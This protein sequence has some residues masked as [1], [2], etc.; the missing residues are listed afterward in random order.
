[1][2]YPSELS[3]LT[4]TVEVRSPPI[5]TLPGFGE[6]VIEQDGVP[7]PPPPPEGEGLGAAAQ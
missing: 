3:L 4:V 1:M 5:A 6:R 7:P 2:A